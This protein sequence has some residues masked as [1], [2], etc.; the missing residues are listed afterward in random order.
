MIDWLTSVIV[1]F[2]LSCSL[3]LILRSSVLNQLGAN[4]SYLAWLIIPAS[5]I[6]PSIELPNWFA[7]INHGQSIQQYFVFA[8]TVALTHWY[9]PIIEYAWAVGGV[10]LFSY[11]CFQYFTFQHFTIMKSE[12]YCQLSTNQKLPHKAQVIN[13]FLPIYISSEVFSPMLV[14]VIKPKLMLPDNFEQ[15]FTEEQQEMILEHELCHYQRGDMVWNC[16]ALL[17]LALFWFH[18]LAWLAFSRYRRDQEL[19]CDQA[20]L[21]RKHISYRINYSKALLVAAENAPPLGFAQLSFKEYG[22]KNV[23]FERI[24]L[25]KHKPKSSKVVTTAM[26]VGALSLLSAMSYAG[27]SVIG[28]NTKGQEIQ[29]IS[30]VEPVYPSQAAADKVE[31]SVVLKFDIT[32]NGDVTNVI[33]VSATPEKYFDK[34]AKIAL[35]QWKYQ[36]SAAGMKNALVQLDFVLSKDSATKFK[37]VEQIQVSG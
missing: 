14:G 3:L 25:I 23:M 9:L 20:V 7:A 36:Q 16:L 27:N 37:Q 29:A 1:P 17:I 11:W 6:V 12:Q 21:A 13:K 30:R 22:D 15:L 10:V 31:G 4:V 28:A 8:D 32:P 24:K 34:S 18:P 2:T 5:L 35:R 19:S 26:F 33:V